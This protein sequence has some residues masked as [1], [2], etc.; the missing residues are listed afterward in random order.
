M[1]LEFEAAR[2][3]AHVY[4]NG[5]LLEGVCENGFI[6][7]GYDLTP[8]LNF[9][10]DNQI[11]VMVDNSFPYYAEGT[12]D[13]L[14]WHDSH[15]HPTHGGLYRNAN[16]YVTDKLHVT[17]P[18]YS[19][20]E[21]QGVYVYTSDETEESATVHIEAEIQNEYDE[22]MTFTY[23][24]DV[25]DMDGAEAASA[26]SEACLLYTSRRDGVKRGIKYMWRESR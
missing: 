21:T 17:L 6:P 23:E 12:T 24:A 26:Q 18:L 14:S 11:T 22:A 8:Y 15:W 7:F 9:G 20:L 16:L 10:G 19:F 3:A 4:L 5:Q 2:Q 1:F 25:E 13:A